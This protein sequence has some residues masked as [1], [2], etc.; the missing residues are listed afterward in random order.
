MF[1]RGRD[2]QG[3]AKI[4]TPLPE[5][6]AHLS[7]S[8]RANIPLALCNKSASHLQFTYIA[9]PYPKKFSPKQTQQHIKMLDVNDFIAER[10]G[11]PNKIRESQ[12]RRHAKEE[13]V[14]QVIEMFEDHRKSTGLARI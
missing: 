5:L 9:P 14:D 12:R 7:Q 11:D 8:P 4:R 13:I 1:M 3:Y 10:G 6:A 2:G